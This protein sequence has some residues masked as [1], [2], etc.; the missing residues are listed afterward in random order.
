M[1]Y[2]ILIG[3]GMADRPMEELGAKTPLE[4]SET[5]NMDLVARCG[6]LGL[7]RTVP[8]GFPPG[9]DVAN[10]SILGYDP[11]KYYTGRAPL[12]AASMGVKLAPKD[13]AFRCNLVT[14]ARRKG[15]LVMDDYSAGHISTEE[16]REIILTLDSALSKEGVRFYPGKSYRHLMVM[17]DGAHECQGGL[18]LTPPH[19]ISGKEI[20]QYLP[21]GKGG[22]GGE[23]LKN[24]VERSREILKDH[25]VN[26]ARKGSGKKTA[27]SIWLWGEGRAPT[28][29]TYGERFAIEGAIISA[30]D[31]MNGIGV[32]AGLEVITVPGAT[33]YLDTDYSAKAEYAMNA[34]RK[35]DLV[36]VHV[37]APDEASHQG[38]LKDKIRAIEDF[39]R[40][41]VGSVLEGVKGFSDF[42]LM[43]ATDHATPVEI[44]THTP[45]P[46]PFAV[47]SGSVERREGK[48]AGFSEK[49]ALE[50]GLL[51][52]DCEAFIEEFI[53][54]AQLA[55]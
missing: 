45:E 23:K 10:L 7:L 30:V 3:D 35:K 46:V 33:G 26:R 15:A 19:D 17:A 1:K 8:P 5:V 27:D 13:L 14:L 31:L 22:E 43:V 53:G 29:P 40:L 54:R 52:E 36:C 2:I 21:G 18:K 47:L 34:L 41:V 12:E 38:S 4:A 24:L 37:E 44:K 9:S 50:T 55:S 16:A 25:P 6:R 28:L 48:G 20:L 32:C 39:D 51:Q 42:R 49:C 11:G